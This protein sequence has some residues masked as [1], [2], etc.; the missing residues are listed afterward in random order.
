VLNKLGPNGTQAR[1]A[2]GSTGGRCDWAR[3][4]RS[5]VGHEH[6]SNCARQR[7]SQVVLGIRMGARKSWTGQTQ[8][9]FHL[10]AWHAAPEQSFSNPQIGDAPIGRRKALRN[11]QISEPGL[12]DDEGG[13]GVE[14]VVMKAI[15]RWSSDRRTDLPHSARL[16]SG[17]RGRVDQSAAVG[18][19][20]GL[21]RLEPDPGRP[22]T[23]QPTL[24]L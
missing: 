24:R 22:A 12:I 2:R 16:W 3:R 13:S 19:Q 7:A 4:K 20:T 21:S 1:A 18:S 23:R 11:L 14:G 8:N 17:T 6:V 10:C 9:G 15:V 5:G